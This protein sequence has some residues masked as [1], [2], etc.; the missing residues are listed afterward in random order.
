MKPK[1]HAYF[2]RWQSPHIGHK[3]LIDQHLSKN[4]KVLIFIR[5]VDIDEKNPFTAEEVK[6]MLGLAF[7]KEISNGLVRLEISPDIFSLNIGRGVGYDVVEHKP[8]DEIKSI[9]ATEIRRKIRE[10]EDGWR[11][12]VIPGV[13]DFLIKKFSGGEK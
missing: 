13:E 3:W 11:E 5:D 9:S 12:M 4:E 6:E 7:E 2:G 10:N 8:N 1:Y